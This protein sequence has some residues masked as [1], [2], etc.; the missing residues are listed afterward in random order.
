MCRRYIT[1]VYHYR[2]CFKTQIRQYKEK[3]RK[4]ERARERDLQPKTPT[5]MTAAL[6]PIIRETQMNQFYN[7]RLSAAALFGQKVVIDCSFE[8]YM[9]NKE[10]ASLLKQIQQCHN[11]NKVRLYCK[12]MEG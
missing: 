12:L 8:E 10:S 11:I 5:K 6:Y 7:Q 9:S 1:D 3:I 2:Y 4:E